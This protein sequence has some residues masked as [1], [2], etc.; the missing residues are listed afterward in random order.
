MTTK[1]PEFKGG[2]VL[3]TE[4]PNKYQALLEKLVRT[5][6][7]NQELQASMKG[8]ARWERYFSNP[9]PRN[10]D[11][12]GFWHAVNT[13]ELAKGLVLKD[14]KQEE[15]TKTRLKIAAL[16]HDLGEIGPGDITSEEIT[17]MDRRDEHRYFID[18]LGILIP[19]LSDEEKKTLIEIYF[20]IA[21]DGT[22]HNREANYFSMIEKLGYLTT[23]VEEWRRKSEDI[24]WG[25]LCSNVLHRQCEDV[26]AMIKK[27]KNS[28][29]YILK[30]KTDLRQMVDYGKSHRTEFKSLTD[31]DVVVWE[32]TLG[33]L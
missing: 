26:K 32:A 31:E 23:A 9:G 5:M 18:N 30:F 28:R 7:T 33:E 15:E 21:H 4:G 14:D 3:E 19:G 11:M 1:S 25:W 2:G 20:S 13:F 10:R 22:K 27:H 6:R 29:D 12:S 17:A 16:V 24:D 8:V